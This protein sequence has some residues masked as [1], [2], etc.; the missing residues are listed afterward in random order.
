MAGPI[1]RAPL[2]IEEL[3]AMA[4]PRSVRSSTI[5]T[6]KDWRAGMSKAL[7]K[8]CTTASAMI[9]PKVM[10]CASVSAA[11]A[12][13]CSGSGGLGPDQQAAAMEP[14]DPDAGERPQKKSDDLPG[15][16]DHAEQQRRV[17]QAVDQP[18]RGQPRHPGA[19]Q[20]DAL[21]GE[22]EPEV[23][24]PQCPPGMRERELDSFSARRWMI[25]A[26]ANRVSCSF[27]SS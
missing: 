14:L 19:D 26:A 18:A 3:M 23:A 4:L 9:S 1:S 11:K 10:M 17:G 12:S 5:R 25:P 24:V 20:R 7:M 13:D 2:A 8:P 6:R 16:A 22:V 21:P 15:E 27:L